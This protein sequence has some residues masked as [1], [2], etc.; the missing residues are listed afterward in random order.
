MFRLPAVSRLASDR[1]DAMPLAPTLQH[2]LSHQGIAYDVI[3][4][5]AT[6]SSTRTA[7]ACHVSG[8]CLAKGVLLRDRRGYLLAVLPASHRIRLSE[9]HDELG[10]DVELAQE[11][12]VESWFRDCERGAIPP[13][14]A[15]YGL[16]MIIDESLEAQPEV[17]FE[18]GDHATLVRVTRDEFAR[19]T[20]GARHR[21]FSAREAGVRVH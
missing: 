9:L 13:V 18:A 7:E 6:L 15:C 3:P 12:E 1:R 14:G 19:L 2:Y 16:E 10:S 21:R 11:T 20:G 4:H 5:E 8:D 17:Y